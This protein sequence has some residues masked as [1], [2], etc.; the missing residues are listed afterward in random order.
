MSMQKAFSTHTKHRVVQ[1]A[2]ERH[3]IDEDEDICHEV[4][5]CWPV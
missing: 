5:L 1:A 3:N 2:T 4:L